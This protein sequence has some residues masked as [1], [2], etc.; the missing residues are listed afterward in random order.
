MKIY[1]VSFEKC[2]SEFNEIFNKIRNIKQI[3]EEEIEV[4]NN[5]H[6]KIMDEI[7]ASFEEKRFQLNKL[8]KE[9]K[10]DLDKKVT[11]VKEELEN[12]LFESNKIIT[13]LER[14]S[15]ANKYYSKK[16]IT[17]K[18][19]SFYYISEINKS[20]LKALD[21]Y[22]KPKRNIDI[23]FNSELNTLNYKNYYFSGIPIPKNINFEEKE[24]KIYIS[25]NIDDFRA[26]GYNIEDIEY[27]IEIKNGILVCT[28]RSLD[29]TT[30]I[31]KNRMFGDLN[32][33]IKA[34]VECIE[35][36]YSEEKIYKNGNLNNPFISFAS[37]KYGNNN[38]EEGKL[39]HDNPFKFS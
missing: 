20:N 1:G 28:I 13:S 8:E 39:N 23:Y 33:K 7:T 25:W 34:C 19:K 15:K 16:S 37:L 29:K 3:I 24:D 38:K 4:I 6:K 21:F 18:I 5:S 10:I 27:V 35:G 12:A 36:I 14:I 22:K 2:I 31:E 32:I 26:K 11:E 30:Y 17:N 9:I